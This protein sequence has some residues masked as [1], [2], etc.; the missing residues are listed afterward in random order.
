MAWV[1]R[2]TGLK[3]S[4]FQW[5]TAATIADEDIT[6]VYQPLGSATIAQ[7]YVNLI[8]SG[9]DDADP[10]IA[11]TFAT[12][13]GWSFTGTQHLT[14][15]IT[16]NGLQTIIVRIGGAIDE[17]LTGYRP[18]GT[19]SF[20]YLRPQAAG[21]D[22]IISCG[23]NG[24]TDSPAVTTFTDGVLAIAR[25]KVYHDGGA[26]LTTLGALSTWGTDP[27]II[28]KA[29]PTFGGYVGDIKAYAIYN[30]EL[31]EGE[32]SEISVNMNAIVSTNDPNPGPAPINWII[33]NPSTRH[34]NSTS[35]ELW[36]ATDNGLFRTF[37]GGRG[38]GKMTL[39]DPS[40][41][42]FDDSPVA[43]INQLTFHWINY[44]RSNNNTLYALAAKT[45]V[46]RVWAYKTTNIGTS[47]TSRG[48]VVS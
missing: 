29:L 22:I 48:V 36:A 25:N 23:Y 5:W 40:N 24:T 16:G 39:P 46:N 47:W 43:T 26:A 17:T 45:S 27:I 13:T 4:V 15:N 37:N 33:Q 18:L 20:Q 34:L 1:E 2:S 12:S 3:P 9:T 11:P 42:E 14:T 30:R 32:V 35:H 10:I 6:V 19:D 38:W 7:S 28:A 8:N 44:D 21:G 31:T 41:A